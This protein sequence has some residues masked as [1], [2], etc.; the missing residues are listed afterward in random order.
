MVW[1]NPA[2][3]GGLLVALCVIV[4]MPAPC[5]PA[6]TDAAAPHVPP[7]FLVAAYA[8]GL[9]HP[10]ALLVL[11]NGD[12]LVAE[13]H[14][15][16]LLRDTDGDGLADVQLPLVTGME[17]PLGIA[18]RRDRLYV[19]NAEGVHA[20]VYLIGRSRL[21][22][23]CKLIADLPA[24]RGPPVT[25][26]LAFN[27]DETTLYVALAARRMVKSSTPACVYALQPDGKGGRVLATLQGAP[28]GL[29]LEPSRGQLWGI[30]TG[31]TP[32][33]LL[34]I[35]GTGPGVALAAGAVPAALVFY[36]RDRYPKAYRGGAFMV[37]QGD[38]AGNAGRILAVPFSDARPSGPPEQFV[39]GFGGGVAGK[40]VALA[41]TRDGALLV[42]DESRGTVWRIAFKCGACTPDP[43][44]TPRAARH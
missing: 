42:A 32:A 29:A 2:R 19:A 33:T 18:L 36:G 16:S 23:S 6:T 40:P 11:P 20:C 44:P 7:N 4:A 13:A 3:A 38:G 30:D 27:R 10:G 31:T 37:D 14:G 1:N 35:G 25:G 41:V 43:V 17:Q 8:R 21:T 28:A 9:S 5:A 22:G 34:A 15:I 12:V 39:D 24:E 26:G